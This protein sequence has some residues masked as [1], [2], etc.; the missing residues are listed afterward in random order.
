MRKHGA[1]VV[2][3]G[4]VVGPDGVITYHGHTNRTQFVSAL[5]TVIHQLEPEPVKEAVKE[6]VKKD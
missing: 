1:F 3:H 2:P 6:A 5:S 4:F